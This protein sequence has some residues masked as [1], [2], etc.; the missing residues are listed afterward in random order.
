MFD[1]LDRFSFELFIVC[2]LFKFILT[3]IHIYIGHA[4]INKCIYVN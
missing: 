2:L 3:Y 4:Y 1:C